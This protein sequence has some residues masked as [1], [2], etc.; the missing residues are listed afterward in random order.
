[1]GHDSQSPTAAQCDGGVYAGAAVFN[2]LITA[3]GFGE[4]SLTASGTGSNGLQVGN[5][6]V[7]A[8][9]RAYIEAVSNAATAQVAAYSSTWIPINIFDFAS[10]ASIQG[11]AAGGLSVAA[12]A[13]DIR[14]YAGSSSEVGRMDGS[15]FFWG[16][17]ANANNLFGVTINQVAADD[18]LLTGKSST[19]VA[20]GL[21]SVTTP[22]VETDDF[23]GVAKLSATLGGVRLLVMGENDASQTINFAV[24]SYGGQASTTK[25]TAGNSLIEL[26]AYQHNGANEFANITADG[27]VRGTRAYVGGALST[28]EILDEDGDLWLSGGLTATTGAFSGVVSNTSRY[29]SATAQPGFLAYNSVADAAVATGATIDFDTEVYDEGGDFA[30]DTFT[31]PVTGRYLF[32][33]AVETTDGSTAN[34]IRG[35][36]LVTSNR[37]YMFDQ[38]DTDA[39]DDYV[40][41]VGAVIA[42]MEAADTALLAADS[43]PVE[44]RALT[45]K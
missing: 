2:G 39:T 7:G 32:T 22:S 36:Q 28:L 23:V 18:Q 1:M 12:T 38:E 6:A 4:H 14:Y 3:A 17:T 43:S 8:T 19:D 35:V 13:G 27:N 21:T 40:G 41:L 15:Q 20:T 26:I 31:A 37:T 34:D 30:A 44:L 5:P 29:N 42:D 9:N 25:S 24:Q 11:D 16:D 45:L 33:V 10:G